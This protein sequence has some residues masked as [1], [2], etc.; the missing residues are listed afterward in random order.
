L[1]ASNL[2]VECMATLYGGILVHEN[3]PLTLADNPPF[4]VV[5]F[6]ASAAIS[7]SVAC[8]T[9]WVRQRG[10]RPPDVGYRE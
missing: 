6:H 3:S 5:N 8:A 9:E 7:S 10:E 2:L 4:L 1:N